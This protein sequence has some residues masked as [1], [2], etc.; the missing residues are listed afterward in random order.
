MM[1]I[2]LRRNV[3]TDGKTDG[4]DE[5]T[6]GQSD[7]LEQVNRGKDK[8]LKNKI[9]LRV[10]YRVAVDGAR[11]VY[12]ILEPVQPELAEA[13]EEKDG[14]VSQAPKSICHPEGSQRQGRVSARID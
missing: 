7:A 3:G 9:R 4:G 1:G 14:Q 6:G 11:R 2:E 13:R 8:G 5:V 12:A 10:G